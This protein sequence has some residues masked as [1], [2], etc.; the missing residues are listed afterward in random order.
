[1]VIISFI[2]LLWTIYSRTYES[3][4]KIQK[5]VIKNIHKLCLNFDVNGTN[6]YIYHF[7]SQDIYYLNLMEYLWT[8]R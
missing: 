1:M 5:N 8:K 4:M 7:E 6:D 3:I 2:I